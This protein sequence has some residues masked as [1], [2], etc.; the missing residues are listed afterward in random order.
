MSSSKTVVSYDF[1]GV[2]H[3]QQRHSFRAITG[4][5]FEIFQEIQ[6]LER[7]QDWTAVRDLCEEQIEKTPEWLT[8]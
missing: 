6:E 4:D 2:K 1:N 8:P 5:E 7:Q 3:V